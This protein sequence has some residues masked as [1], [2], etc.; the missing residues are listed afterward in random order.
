MEKEE[1]RPIAGYEYYEVSN[2]GQVRSISRM[3]RTR[4]KGTKLVKGRILSQDTTGRYHMV[5][6][7]KMGK[8]KNVTVHRQVALAFIP[9]PDGK[10]TVDHIDRNRDNNR[11]SN[12]RWATK[13]E[14]EENKEYPQRE[15]YAIK[16]GKRTKFD[17]VQSCARTLGLSASKISACLHGKRKT[18]GGYS[19]TV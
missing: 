15:I 10:E 11:K 19:F 18:H 5:T 13:S 16:N 4:G 1:W 14:Q 3:V 8:P 7:Y 12:L 2:F 17:G 6:L 9:N